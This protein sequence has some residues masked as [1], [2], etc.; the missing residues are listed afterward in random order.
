MKKLIISFIL[1]GVLFGCVNHFDSANNLEDMLPTPQNLS[2]SEP[3][4][5][6][7]E[8]LDEAGNIIA[9]QPVVSLTVSAEGAVYYGL[10]T[11]EKDV[12]PAHSTDG[13]I[14]VVYPGDG[15]FES[16][17]FAQGYQASVQVTIQV[18]VPTIPDIP[19]PEID[20]SDYYTFKSGDLNISP[21]GIIIGLN[22]ELPNTKV[23]IPREIDG[24]V[25]K[26]F[27]DEAFRSVPITHIDF[28]YVADG[29]DL[30]NTTFRGTK[31]EY[32]RITRNIAS[33]GSSC[34]RQCGSLVAVDFENNNEVMT[35]IG[36]SAFRDCSALE[37]FEVPR[38]IESMVRAIFRG[39][40]SLKNF[41]FQRGTKIKYIGDSTFSGV[42]INV[43]LPFPAYDNFSH[44]VDRNGDTWAPGT[45]IGKE[46][47]TAVF[48]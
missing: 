24:I 6:M 16:I 47:Y 11:S 9:I 5:E 20:I 19:L 15:T 29:F 21:E 40:V 3:V 34:F 2:V 44:W 26:K 32:L 1:A 30:G 46:E 38:F 33:I 18:V 4:I 14:E 45:I 41:S 39:C 8:V 17:V 7:R 13:N 42:D 48:N 27:N 22:V 25:L 12:A 36:E 43:P 31:I 10:K 28:R 35:A 37:R 23:V